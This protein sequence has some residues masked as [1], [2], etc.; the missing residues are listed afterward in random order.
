[1]SDVT[2]F[3]SSLIRPLAIKMELDIFTKKKKMR[4]VCVMSKS[5]FLRLFDIG[6]IIRPLATP[7]NKY[8]CCLIS[9]SKWYC[10]H[11]SSSLHHLEEKG[12]SFQFQLPFSLMIHICVALKPVSLFPHFHSIYPCPPFFFTLKCLH[13]P[14]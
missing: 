6:V 7:E 5:C 9:Q 14:N 2:S 11:S 8:N 13:K 1:M 10:H 12:S 4:Y 3:T